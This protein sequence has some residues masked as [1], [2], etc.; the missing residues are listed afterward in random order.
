MSIPTRIAPV[1]LIIAISF[2]FLHQVG[3]QQKFLDKLQNAAKKTQE[4]T[5][6]QGAQQTPQQGAEPLQRAPPRGTV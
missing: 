2:G 6:P 4:A 1:A 5:Q 3:A